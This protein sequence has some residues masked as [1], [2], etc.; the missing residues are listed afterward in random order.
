M[1]VKVIMYSSATLL[2]HDAECRGAY[3]DCA[4]MCESQSY[5]FGMSQ[6]QSSQ[7]EHQR[8]SSPCAGDEE[9]PTNEPRTKT[10]T[11]HEIVKKCHM[12]GVTHLS[13]PW[14]PSQLETE[15]REYSDSSSP[16]RLAALVA[17]C[18]AAATSPA[19]TAWS[20]MESHAWTYALRGRKEAQG[21]AWR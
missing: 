18:M 13:C 8:P 6:D 3:A 5:S 17:C 7:S 20:R 2:W 9:Q 21:R 4:R 16:A 1:C 10:S 15:A 12:V 11:Y 19:C 14:S